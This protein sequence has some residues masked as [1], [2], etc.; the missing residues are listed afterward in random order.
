MEAVLVKILATL[1]DW[2]GTS[3]IQSAEER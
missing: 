3:E 2:R 1:E